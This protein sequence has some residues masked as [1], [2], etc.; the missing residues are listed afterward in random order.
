M[1]ILA[2]V[3]IKLVMISLW[4]QDIKFTL[5]LPSNYVYAYNSSIN[6]WLRVKVVCSSKVIRKL[7]SVHILFKFRQRRQEDCLDV[8]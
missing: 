1:V 7:I 2:V 5:N 4:R 6:P 8:N 3:V